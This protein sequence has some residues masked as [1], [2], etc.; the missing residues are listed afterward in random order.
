MD[1][2]YIVEDVLRR[3]NE[4]ATATYKVD[5]QNYLQGHVVVTY[6]TDTS[7]EFKRPGVIKLPA[8]FIAELATIPIEI[9]G[10]P[11]EIL[12]KLSHKIIN[13]Q[14]QSI[15]EQQKE[16]IILPGEQ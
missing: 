3:G 4:Q 2:L 13:N 7:N 14:G 10:C 6:A 1:N 16:K 9:Q 11:I 8:K 5:I 15:L 12:I